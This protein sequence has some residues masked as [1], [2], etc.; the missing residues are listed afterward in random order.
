MPS[1]RPVGSTLTSATQAHLGGPLLD[2]PRA[3]LG[4]GA[5]LAQSPADA[6]PVP[7]SCLWPPARH[8]P[9]SAARPAASNPAQPKPQLV[10]SRPVPQWLRAHARPAVHP[11]PAGWEW[12]RMEPARR[13][14]WIEIAVRFP[15]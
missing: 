10:Q 6:V 5:A 12:T 15:S 4:A 11:G 3:V 8:Q 9:A 14:K 13:Q 2:Q 7:P 1:I